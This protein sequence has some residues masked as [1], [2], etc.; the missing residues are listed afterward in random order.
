MNDHAYTYIKVEKTPE[1]PYS[2]IVMNK[3]FALRYQKTGM[4]GRLYFGKSIRLD[5]PLGVLKI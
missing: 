2:Y 3:A 5:C 4:Y 1:K